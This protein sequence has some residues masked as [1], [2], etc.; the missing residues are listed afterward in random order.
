VVNTASAVSA[1]TLTWRATAVPRSSML[2]VYMAV[3]QRPVPKLP[4]RAGRVRSFDPEIVRVER[5]CMAVF[6]YIEVL[7]PK[8]GVG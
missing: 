1:R 6:E 3:R 2:S 4:A 8:P 7:G 5:G